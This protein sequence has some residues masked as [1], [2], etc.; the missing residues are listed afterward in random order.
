MAIDFDNIHKIDGMSANEVEAAIRNGAKLNEAI[1]SEAE[2]RQEEDSKLYN[3]ISKEKTLLQGNIDAERTAREAKDTEL[4]GKITDESTVREAKD[5]ELQEA[6]TAETSARSADVTSLRLIIDEEKRTREAKDAEL[7]ESINKRVEFIQ[8]YENELDELFVVGEGIYKVLGRERPEDGSITVDTT[9]RDYYIIARGQQTDNMVIKTVQIKV[10]FYGIYERLGVKDW[11]GIVGQPSG[12]RITW[13]EWTKYI[14]QSEFD[15]EIETI[16]ESIDSDMKSQFY[17]Y[18]YYDGREVTDDSADFEL[19]EGTQSVRCT[20]LTK[21]GTITVPYKIGDTIVTGIADNAFENSL[22]YEVILPNTIESVGASAFKN[23]TNLMEISIPDSVTSVKESAFEGCSS[24]NIMHWSDN[25]AMILANT[26]KDCAALGELYIGEIVHVIDETAFNGCTTDNLCFYTVDGCTIDTFAQ[27]HNFKTRY[28][29]TNVSSEKMS[30]EIDSALSEERMIRDQAD[31]ALSDRLNEVESIANKKP[32]NILDGTPTG[33]LN[34]LFDSGN[35]L[36]FTDKNPNATLVDASLTG[37]LTKGATGNY[38][39]SFGGKSI[40][41]GKRSLA[42]GTTTIAK[43]NYSHAEGDNSVA[44]GNDSHAECYRTLAQGTGSHSEGIDTIAKGSYSHSEG[45]TTISTGNFSH[46]EGLKTESKGEASHAEGTYTTA[47]GYGSHSEGSTTKANG[48]SSHAE[49]ITSKAIGKA[50]HAEGTNTEAIGTNAHAEGHKTIAGAIASELVSTYV[51][52]STAVEEY[53]LS[54]ANGFIVGHYFGECII[55]RNTGRKSFHFNVGKIEHISG[56][57]LTITMVNPVTDITNRYKTYIFMGEPY[58]NSS[59]DG[60]GSTPTTNNTEMGSQ[61]HTEGNRTMALGNH[62]HAEGNKTKALGEMSHSEGYET[63]AHSDYQH[64]QG[65]FN[66]EDADNKYADIIGNGTSDSIR[67][68]AYTLDWQGNVWYQ[69]DIKIGGTSYDD[70]INVV[71][72]TE[73]DKKQDKVE[74]S[75]IADTET[76]FVCDLSAVHNEEIRIRSTLASGITFVIPNEVYPDDYIT[77]LS[78]GT[79]DTAPQISYSATGIIQWIGTDCSIVDGKS[80][81][82]PKPNIHYDI[83]IYFN[84]FQ[85]IGLVNGFVTATIPNS[86]IVSETT[87]ATS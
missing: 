45:N 60:S 57:T 53:T 47:S 55:E 21:T 79:G 67:S 86:G 15:S 77:S 5:T 58:S 54:D 48:D 62:A 3:E 12:T 2:K 31:K 49:G 65:K 20:N 72:E 68:N 74:I 8:A 22:C 87:E 24:L 14:T 81:F 32:N 25:T 40:A 51:D 9:W 76:S 83:V 44:L 36:D 69:G 17:G 28:L 10:S 43:G 63:I 26:F 41:M 73:L 70:G 37:S 1:S 33:S 16:K 64:V 42:E 35:T 46:S 52:G 66:V 27:Q 7:Q 82:A 39:T 29:I 11:R 23:A 84:G 4:D 30:Q 19:V 34:Q 6:I 56:N 59:T 85:F 80:I 78:F 61:S 71:T 38:A 50:S 18:K 13:S 75:E